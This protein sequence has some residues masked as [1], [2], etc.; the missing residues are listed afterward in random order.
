MENKIVEQ[1]IVEATEEIALASSNKAGKALKV[2]VGIGV[3]AFVGRILYKRVIKPIVAKVKAKKEQA[4]T[5]SEDDGE[6]KM[7]F[8]DNGN[9]IE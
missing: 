9:P 5:T 1:E 2:T 8:D 7:I 4:K 6:F 3:A